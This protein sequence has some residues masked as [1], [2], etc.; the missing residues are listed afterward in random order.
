MKCNSIVLDQLGLQNCRVAIDV[1]DI[2]MV[3]GWLGAAG[4]MSAYYLVSTG[5]VAPDSLRYHALNI[6]A[7]I[8]LATACIATAA[9]PSMVANLLFAAIGIQMT[10]RLRGRLAARIMGLVARRP[11]A[12]SSPAPGASPA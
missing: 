3:I 9:W 10:W 1:H 5:R 4:T 6:S 11:E 12:S 2:A 7:C 8:A